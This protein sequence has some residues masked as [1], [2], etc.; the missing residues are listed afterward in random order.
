IPN[1]ATA[2]L[3]NGDALTM[4]IMKQAWDPN[5]GI[6]RNFIPVTNF[7]ELATSGTVA[8]WKNL[9]DY[10][11]EPLTCPGRCTDNAFSVLNY[12]D[13]GF[14]W[15]SFDGAASNYL[16]DL[17]A[18]PNDVDFGLAWAVSG[19]DPNFP[20]FHAREVLEDVEFHAGGDVGSPGAFEL[21]DADFD[22]DNDVDGVDFLIWQRGLGVGSTHAE[23]D[24]NG[25]SIVNEAD[26]AVWEAQY[27]SP[28]P[29]SA[30][31][32]VS[33]TVPEPASAVLV[34]LGLAWL[35][36][37]RARGRAGSLRN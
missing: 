20:A 31:L 1:N 18:D 13:N 5:D 25:D 4:E 35:G 6:V 24:A 7:S 33:S 14:D 30:P 26:L 34:L 17:N 19:S 10:L 32:S 21:N 29:L 36:R 15:P 8:L 23:G 12:D 28:P 37:C 9:T 22:D 16:T 11:S 3:F 27:G 2:V